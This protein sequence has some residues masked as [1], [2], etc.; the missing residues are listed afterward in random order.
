MFDVPVKLISLAQ[1]MIRMTHHHSDSVVYQGG[2]RI[3]TGG[4]FTHI[5]SGPGKEKHLFKNGLQTL[6]A[7][8]MS[9]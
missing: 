4:V 5:Q 6:Y 9:C 1:V 7:T 8:Y 3:Q 2:R